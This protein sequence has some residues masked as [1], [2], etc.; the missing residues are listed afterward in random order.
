[1]NKLE[2]ITMVK[3]YGKIK[4]KLGEVMKEKNLTRHQLS[5]MTNTRF[6]V[7]TNGILVKLKELTVMFC[8]VFAMCLNV[9]LMILLNMN[10][11]NISTFSTK[12]L[13]FLFC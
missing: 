2:Q 12:V 3:D 7:K 4:I 13:I 11:K 8:H 9:K 6:E 5:K 1:M 10:H